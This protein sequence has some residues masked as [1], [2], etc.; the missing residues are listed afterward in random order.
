[1]ATQTDSGI[2]LGLYDIQNI[3]PRLR[4]Y[5]QDKDF[6]R[7]WAL[8]QINTITLLKI[9]SEKFGTVPARDIRDW[10]FL[11]PEFDEL[12]YQFNLVE[13]SSTTNANN[14]IFKVTNAIAAILNTSHRLLIDTV[15]VK[16]TVT[17]AATD[18]ATTRDIANGLVMNEVARIVNVGS[19]D[20]G[21]SGYTLVTVRRAHPS[22]SYTG[23]APAVTTSA[24]ITIVNLAVRSNSY[25]Q[26]PVTKNSKKLENL[27]QISRHSYGLGEMMVQ[28]DGIDT[29]LAEGTQA[30]LNIAYTIAETWLMKVIERAILCGR[31][32][33]KTIGDDLEHET[34]GVLEWILADTDHVIDLKGQLPT[35]ERMN[36]W[37]RHMADISGVKE[38]WMFMGTIAAEGLANQYD[39]K[40]IWQTNGTLSL[41]YQIKIITLEGVGRDL[42]V[43][44]VTSP[45]LNELGMSNEAIVLNLTEYNWNEKSK[46]GSFQ[47]AYKVPF[48]DL[49]KDPDGYKKS[50]GF[51][52]KW[53]ELYGAWGLVRRLRETHFRIVGFPIPNY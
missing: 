8:R 46:Y 40:T 9:I 41:H 22:D 26:P 36:H 43:H 28:G 53:R 27:I 38:L 49:P 4:K 14:N 35:V 11:Y 48:A 30:H 52:G 37:I 6:F 23:T 2:I 17:A 51:M 16:E 20:S 50:D 44:L 31:M 29:F 21:G 42:T 7:F 15:F 39:K 24:T 18:M 5:A 13:L 32:S 19:P 45:L 33:A 25:P 12:E 34:G 1:M 47:V 3:Q 10:K